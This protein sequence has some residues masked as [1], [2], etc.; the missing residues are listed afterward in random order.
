MYHHVKKL[1][2]TVNIGEPDPRFG[3]MLLEQFGVV[4]SEIEGGEGP[5]VDPYAPNRAP[6]QPHQ[7]I[8]DCPIFC[9]SEE[10]V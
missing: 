7:S 4:D 2:Y 8:L 5:S 9:T 10:L 3:R 6:K 1:I